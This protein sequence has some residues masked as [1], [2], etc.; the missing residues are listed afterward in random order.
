VTIRRLLAIAEGLEP[1]PSAKIDVRVI[2]ATCGAAAPGLAQDPPLIR[3]LTRVVRETRQGEP[4]IFWY[5][6]PEPIGPVNG[7]D[8][9]YSGRRL[10]AGE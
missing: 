1:V 3:Q 4:W 8:C 5:W 7:I 9:G 10:V 2:C 6:T